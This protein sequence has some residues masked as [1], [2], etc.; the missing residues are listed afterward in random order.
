MK[1]PPAAGIRVSIPPP[2]TDHPVLPQSAGAHR[3]TPPDPA[4]PPGTSVMPARTAARPPAAGRAS[5]VREQTGGDDDFSD[6]LAGLEDAEP[7]GESPGRLDLADDF[8]LDPEPAGTDAAADD[9]FA[10]L[11]DGAGARFDNFL[12]DLGVPA[13]AAGRRRAGGAEPTATRTRAAPRKSGRVAGGRVRSDAAAAAVLARATADAAPALPGRTRE[14]KRSRGDA[15][16]AAAPAGGLNPFTV[17]SVVAALAVLAMVALFA[18]QDAVNDERWTEAIHQ[19]ADL[20]VRLR[21]FP[22][23]APRA[24]WERFR[25]G[26]DAEADLLLASVAPAGFDTPGGLVRGAVEDMKAYTARRRPRAGG[27]GRYVG[28]RAL[29]ELRAAVAGTSIDRKFE[30]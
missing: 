21:D 27:G 1:T 30:W 28:E 10:G 15:A 12:D 24:E 25:T 16:D 20:H 3:A 22:A 2:R 5:R 6:L 14:L 18:R 4:T 9:P 19:A 29:R 13:P 8:E 26:F 11:D 7:A 23:D 17:G